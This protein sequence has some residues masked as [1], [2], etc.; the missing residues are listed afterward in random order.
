M[1]HCLRTI[2]T[3]V[4]LT[5]AVGCASPTKTISAKQIAILESTQRGHENLALALSFPLAPEPTAAIQAADAEFTAIESAAKV[6]IAQ[7]PHVEDSATWFDKLLS[8]VKIIA[9]VILIIA[10]LV[11]AI[12]FGVGK[13]IRRLFGAAGM[14]IPTGDRHR[15]RMAVKVQEE[16][17]TFDE[18]IAAE[19]GRNRHFNTAYQWERKQNGKRP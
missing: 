1:R 17:V 2:L 8:V 10:V 3:A 4:A 9:V 5:A 19:R 13:F 16:A 14:F 11:A 12:Y 6:T 18:Y 15:A 7:V